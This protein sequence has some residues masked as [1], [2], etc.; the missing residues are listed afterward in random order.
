MCGEGG[1]GGG[2]GGRG[3]EVERHMMQAG[4]R[5]YPRQQKCKKEHN[6]KRKSRQVGREEGGGKGKKEGHTEA[7]HQHTS[8]HGALEKVPSSGIC[9]NTELAALPQYY[10]Y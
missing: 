6:S 9:R 4:Y 10:R 3:K 8:S 7:P 2:G 1:G 5:N